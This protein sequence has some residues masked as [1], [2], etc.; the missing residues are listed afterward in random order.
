[1][2]WLF[3]NAIYR[4]WH[5]ML[6]MLPPPLLLPLSTFMLCHIVFDSPN[7]IHSCNFHFILS[8]HNSIFISFFRHIFCS[9]AV[10]PLL[11]F[12]QSLSFRYHQTVSYSIRQSILGKPINTVT[13]SSYG[14]NQPYSYLC[15]YWLL[16]FKKYQLKCVKWKMRAESSCTIS[17]SAFECIT[18]ICVMECVN[19][20][21]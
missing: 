1:M 14:L 8:S 10:L 12:F 7:I 2:K 15:S 16:F 18:H 9:L 21:L 5:I 6:P 20:T 4:R 19:G 17:F 13:L 3:V 11:F